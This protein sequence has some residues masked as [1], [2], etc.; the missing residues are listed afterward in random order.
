VT[1]AAGAVAAAE[2]RLRFAD[3]SVKAKI[4]GEG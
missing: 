1:S 4:E 3:A 2:V